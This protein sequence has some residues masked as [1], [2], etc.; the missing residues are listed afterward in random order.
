MP[1]LGYFPVSGRLAYAEGVREYLRTRPVVQLM[2]DGIGVKIRPSL[3]QVTLLVGG[4][5]L[6]IFVGA[7]L[8]RFRYEPGHGRLP[9]TTT[10]AIAVI[11]VSILAVGALI[12]VAVNV[13]VRASPDRLEFSNGGRRTVIPW[14]RVKDVAFDAELGRLRVLLIDGA[15]RTFELPYL[16]GPGGP[17]AAGNLMRACATYRSL[18]G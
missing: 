11:V 6:I 8:N 18:A 5:G 17:D 15:M 12:G 2:A 14:D 10:A 9:L 4:L 3:K 1:Q 13:F 16:S 7:V